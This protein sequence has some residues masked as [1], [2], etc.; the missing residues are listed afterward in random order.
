M[1]VIN[2][3][4]FLMV[5]LINGFS[6][7]TSVGKSTDLGYITDKAKLSIA[8]DGWAFS[9]WGIIYSLIGCFTIY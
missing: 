3:I 1:Q 7:T 2:G 6:A 4:A 5:L 9:I 8:P